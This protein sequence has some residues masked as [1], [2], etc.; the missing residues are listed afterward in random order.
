[1]RCRSHSHSLIGSG[2]ALTALVD[3]D[4]GK[5]PCPAGWN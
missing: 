4:G 3:A 1:M 2:L 5:H